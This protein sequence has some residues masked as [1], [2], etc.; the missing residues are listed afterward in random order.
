[1]LRF[2]VNTHRDEVAEN[3]FRKITELDPESGAAHLQAGILFEHRGR[4]ADAVTANLNLERLR[5]GSGHLQTL[6]DAA[7]EEAYQRAP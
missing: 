4:E 5:F 7:L 3:E 1:L 6:R 2:Y